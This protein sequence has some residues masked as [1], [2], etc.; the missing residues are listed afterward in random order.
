[1]PFLILG[2]VASDECAVASQVV[3]ASMRQLIRMK[4]GKTAKI[5]DIP[6]FLSQCIQSKVGAQL[7]TAQ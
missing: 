5:K 4:E 1:M 3:I 2:T 7:H 6:G